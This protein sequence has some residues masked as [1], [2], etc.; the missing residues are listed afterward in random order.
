MVNLLCIGVGTGGTGGMCPP[1]FH[2]LLYKLLTTLCVVSDCAPP[3]KKSFLHLCYGVNFCKV[4]L[5]Q[6][7]T[8]GTHQQQ[9]CVSR[10][11]CMMTSSFLLQSKNGS[12]CA[13]DSTCLPLLCPSGSVVR[14]S[15]YSIH[16]VLGSNC[17]WILVIF[18]N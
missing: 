9:C 5:P 3:I 8:L 12:L 10:Q 4:K 17:S 2:K 15:H 14:V 7:M 18:L 1:K 6:D 13:L 11:E 16:K